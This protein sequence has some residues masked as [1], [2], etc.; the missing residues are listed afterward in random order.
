[1]PTGR[2]TTN[3][4]DGAV[5]PVSIAEPGTATTQELQVAIWQR[6]CSR[7]HPAC[8]GSRAARSS[9]AAFLKTLPCLRMEHDR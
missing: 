6:S 9:A 7:E 8:R 5:R 4:Q 2:L 1:M 3:L